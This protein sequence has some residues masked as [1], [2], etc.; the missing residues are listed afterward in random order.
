M[1]KFRDLHMSHTLL[2]TLGQYI[3][4]NSFIFVIRGGSC[5]FFL[6][7]L[8]LLGT[9]SC[10]SLHLSWD[11]RRLPPQSAL[12]H[13]YSISRHTLLT[14]V[15]F[16]ISFISSINFL[17][18]SFNDFCFNFYYIFPVGLSFAFILFY[19]LVALGFELNLE[20][21]SYTST[22]SL[23]HAPRPIFFVYFSC[24]FSLLPGDS[25]EPQ[26]SHLHLL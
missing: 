17:F 3:C 11:Y 1:K 21:W 22:S 18:F 23:S 13:K 5:Y 10:L 24:R 6:A 16:L 2:L 20:P 12:C 4:Y 9:A 19:F 14:D 7:D 25:L 26:S 8:K 15:Q